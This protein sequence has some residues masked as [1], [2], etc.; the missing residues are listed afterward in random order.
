MI[1][2]INDNLKNVIAGIKDHKADLE[3]TLDGIRS[4]MATSVKEA[5]SYKNEVEDA[6]TIVYSL[7]NEIADLEK[8]LDELNQKFGSKDFKE[9]LA[10][11][12]KEI[13]AKII[14]KKSLINEQGR[15]ILTLTEKARSLKEQLVDLRERK[16]ATEE[17]LKKTKILESYY[18]LRVTDIIKFAEEH[19]EELAN[20][21]DEVPQDELDIQEDID[22]TGVIDGSI[23]EEIDEISGNEPDQDLLQNALA[24]PG[25]IPVYEKEAEEEKSVEIDVS[26]A[27]QLDNII[28]DATN[29]MNKANELDTNDSDSNNLETYSEDINP[30][31]DMEGLEKELA[32]EETVVDDGIELENSEVGL[33]E[34]E[35][36]VPDAS[37]ASESTVSE[38]GPSS[39]K[40]GL[41]EI[42][43]YT[44]ETEVVNSE[45]IEEISESIE[46]ETEAQEETTGEVQDLAS[47]FEKYDMNL[48]MFSK[49]EREKL[50]KSDIRANMVHFVKTMRKHNIELD[51]FYDNANIL[52]ALKPRK[53]EKLLTLIE[54]TDATLEDMLLVFKYLDKV[55]IEKFEQ[56]V[57]AESGASLASCLGQAINTTDDVIG[58]TLGLS[59][60]AEET[61][62]K[63]ATKEE[64]KI[65]NA[66][67]D[68][69]L[70]NYREVRALNVDN[71]ED[72]IS[73][74]PHRFTLTHSKF[75][76]ILDKYDTEDLIR[77][78]NKNPAVIDKL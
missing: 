15:I 7:E 78:I 73:K 54:K 39:D 30:Y 29:F 3:N 60:K 52:I 38:E 16:I 65:M 56:L 28:T 41:I 2:V 72:C 6:R 32:Q 69:V 49:A 48:K 43:G 74:Y 34:I 20:Y 55:N 53:L 26:T 44:P 12:N 77:C 50:E 18:E 46:E 4:D 10:A 71:I 33:V 61:L 25:E 21:R 67:P 51:K 62:K 19:P 23:F 35:G 70:E 24:N 1:K 37:K 59:R 11:G 64:M 17:E 13:N 5:N 27:N 68:M 31:L 45:I 22:I 9:I 75:H 63:T 58:S 76:E 57:N 66:L 47:M 8:D 40:V 42:E 36:Y 14:E